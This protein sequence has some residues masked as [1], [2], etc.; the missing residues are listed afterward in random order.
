MVS[1]RRLPPDVQEL[2]V[3]KVDKNRLSA[4]LLAGQK[5]LSEPSSVLS[6][7][8]ASGVA[9]IATVQRREIALADSDFQLTPLLAG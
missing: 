5:C 4:L 6:D 1:P 7:V 3:S 9:S 2:A 8:V